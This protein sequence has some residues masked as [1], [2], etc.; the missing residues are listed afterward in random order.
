MGEYPNKI[1]PA[2]PG[3]GVVSE[4]AMLQAMTKIKDFNPS[5]NGIP[6]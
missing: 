2:D 5:M 6:Q 3:V 1:Y 4:K